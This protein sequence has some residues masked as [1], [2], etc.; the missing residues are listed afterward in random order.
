METIPDLSQ[1]V[2]RREEMIEAQI[3]IE[4]ASIEESEMEKLKNFKFITTVLEHKPCGG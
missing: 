3:I 2:S 1:G 4:G